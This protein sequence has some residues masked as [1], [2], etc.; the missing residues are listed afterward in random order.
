M[1]PLGVF[2]VI[3][4]CKAYFELNKKVDF[5]KTVFSGWYDK[6][7]RYIKIVCDN[8][9][10]YI[11]NGYFTIED[12][13]NYVIF[14][15]ITNDK[16]KWN[17]IKHVNVIEYTSFLNREEDI[18]RE[19]VQN[20]IDATEVKT[21]ND[22]FVINSNNNSFMYDFIINKYISPVFYLKMMEYCTIGHISSNF[23]ESAEHKKFREL[24]EKIRN[25][26][27]QT[28]NKIKR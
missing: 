2:S 24:F 27:Q 26:K 19:F 28:K 1:N 20:V 6:Q 22:F 13:E 5:T 25:V 14:S 12:F 4:N 18:D 10:D 7:P 3:Q 17:D 9:K 23:D 16:L 15:Y 21:L 11:N 8:I